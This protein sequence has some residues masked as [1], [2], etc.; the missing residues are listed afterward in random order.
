[1]LIPHPRFLFIVSVMLLAISAYAEL[2]DLGQGKR[3]ERAT[4]KVTDSNQAVFKGG[5]KVAD[6]P[7]IAGVSITTE[8]NIEVF[9]EVQ[10]DPAHIGKNGEMLAFISFFPLDSFDKIE[11]VM[12]GG[13]WQ[14]WNGELKALPPVQNARP[15]PAKAKL[16]VY[17]G[18]PLKTAGRYEITAAYRF[19]D[20]DVVMHPNRPLRFN[21]V[22]ASESNAAKSYDPLALARASIGK[23]VNLEAVVPSQCYTKTEGV[24]NPCWTC[25]TIGAHPNYQ[26][27]LDLQEEYSFSDFALT[28]RWS[29]LF[30][31]HSAI[32]STISEEDVLSY[33]REDNYKPLYDNL[34]GRTD[35]IGW[36]PDLDFALGFDKEGFAKDGSNWRAIRYKPFLGTFWPTNGN[37]D[38]V[39]IRLPTK[40]RESRELYKI[41]LSILEAA[42]TCQPNVSKKT[43]C[44]RDV[45]PLN[46]TIAG[47][48]LNG[49]GKIGGT[50]TQIK[51]LPGNYVGSAS[52]EEVRRY[53]YPQETE[54]LHTV[55]YVDPDS[56][57]LMSTRMKE[58][59][60]SRKVQNLGQWALVYNYE[61]ELEDKDEGLLPIFTGSPMIGLQN[62]FGW[63]LQGFIEDQHGRLRLQTE[64]ENRFCMGCHSAIGVT[65][66]Q[67]F[68]LS[69]KVP[70][71][72]GWRHQD[73][74]GIPDV[75]Q[76][77]QEKPEIL[78]YFERVKGGDEFRANT[79]ILKRFFPNGKLD[80]ESVRRAAPGGDK[81]MTFLVAPSR[82]RAIALNRAYMA[83]VRTQSF[84]QGRDT[85]LSPPDN[86]H[87]FIENGDTDLA[88][89]GK[90]FPDG[91]LWLK[92]DGVF[93]KANSA[94]DTGASGEE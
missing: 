89:A 10:I 56:P 61:R 17:K 81:D 85:I 13:D 30:I 94:E 84:D 43:S 86:V 1:M 15:L 11:F 7:A 62:D 16:E 52:D 88:E 91:S 57:T 46:E 20:K 5:V 55:R 18:T 42:M 19:D 22:D 40:F 26:V 67:T 64:E 28:N 69:R 23:T 58:V 77:K 75:P 51:G 70:G 34:E 36:K 60:Y 79:E 72:A 9:A 66:D 25:H 8:H 27:G 12:T 37:T 59:R 35:Y 24:S 21:V 48:D 74:R 54:F 38:D 87:P 53:V 93:Q 32:T 31:D 50:I 47:I 92:W 44:R 41:N 33:I 65:A 73:L 82:E 3:I 2:P 49:D 6:G 4:G 63:L 78:T 90:V 80:E 29:N 83:L 14:L 45:E 68:T 71:L 39:M 76:A